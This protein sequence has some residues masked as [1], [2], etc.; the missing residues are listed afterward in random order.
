MSAA[1]VDPAD[2]ANAHAYLVVENGTMYEVYLVAAS[3][4]TAAKVE[5]MRAVADKSA[6]VPEAEIAI[7]AFDRLEMAPDGTFLKLT[8]LK[9]PLKPGESVTIVLTTDTGE[10]LTTA[11]TVK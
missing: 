6:P 8:G 5:L 9:H 3:S 10:T 2:D 1:R 7:P 4:E 11:A